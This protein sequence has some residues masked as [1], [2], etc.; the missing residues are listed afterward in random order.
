MNRNVLATI[1]IVLAIG[2]YATFTRAKLA[3]VN[4]VKTVNS[5]YISA[6]KNADELIKVRDAVRKNYNEISAEDRARLDKMIP[7][8]VDNIRLIIDMNSIALR[9]GFSLRN[10]KATASANS[11]RQ[12]SSVSSQ[13]KSVG[14]AGSSDDLSIPTP[15]LDTVTV[16]FSV[17]STYQQFIDLL[18]DLEADLRVMDLTHLTVTANSTGTYDY[19]VELKTYWLRQQ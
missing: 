12:S 7:N 13:Q 1:L 2:I 4:D 3:E 11:T 18:R 10:I 17:S 6:I 5:Q 14:S 16:S 19:G 15:I 9:H 8:T